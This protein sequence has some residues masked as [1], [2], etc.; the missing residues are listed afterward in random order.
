[1]LNFAASLAI[2]IG[3]AHSILGER[4]ILVRLFR[5]KNLPELLGS[6]FFTRRTLRFA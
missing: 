1:M 5:R 6:D 3:A 4:Y 2:F